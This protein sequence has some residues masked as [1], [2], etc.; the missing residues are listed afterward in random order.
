MSN[1]SKLSLQSAILINL[2][3][4]AGAGIFVNIVDLTKALN[5]AGGILYLF[6]GLFMFPLVF[7]FAQLV[8]TYPS[9]GFYAFAKPLSP[10]LGF[11]SNWTYFF[12]KL[13]SASLL[14]HVA[15]SFIQA[16][17]PTLFA[18]VDPVWIS[19]VILA[20]FIYLNFLNVRTGIIIQR[21]F[22][23][24]K[25]IPM[26]SLIILGIYLFDFNIFASFQMIPV[27]SFITILPLVLYCYTGFEAACSISR[28]IQNAEK[29]AP[30]AIFY[31]FFSIILLYVVFQT[32]LSMILLPN[33]QSLSSYT[34]AYP[35]IASLIPISAWLQTKLATTISFLIGFSALGATYGLLFSNSWNLY[36][37][38]QNKLTFIPNTIGCLNKHG[39]PTFA[40]LVEGLICVLFLLIT[41]GNKILLM[42]TASLGCTITYTISTIAFLHLKKWSNLTGFL[43]LITCTGFII[44]CI[45]SSIKYNFVSLNLFIFMFIVGLIMYYRC[46]KKR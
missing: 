43:S 41:N 30:K 46:E 12:G 2:N 42:Q 18:S 25:S 22:I 14:L 45:I 20:I 6:V 23:A 27:S 21:C 29:N 39:I 15:A 33:I 38:A 19:I 17:I 3:I 44:S 32:L 31:S 37:L 13:A 9:G 4:M 26:I 10:F 1:S 35:Y 11:V 24:A 7:T 5:L 16:L 8:K 36:T 28:N 40:V 34:Q